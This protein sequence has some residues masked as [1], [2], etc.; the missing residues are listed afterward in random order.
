MEQQVGYIYVLTNKAMP[1]LLKIGYTQRTIQERVRE[2]SS[3]TGVPHDFEVAYSIETLSPEYKESIIHQHLSEY[4]VSKKGKEF[5]KISL[6]DAKHIIERVAKPLQP[7][8]VPEPPELTE[9][10]KEL[11]KAM[12]QELLKKKYE[13]RKKNIVKWW[14]KNLEKNLETEMGVQSEW[15]KKGFLKRLITKKPKPNLDIVEEYHVAIERLRQFKKAYTFSVF[16]KE[17]QG[18]QGIDQVIGSYR[19]EML[20]S[21]LGLRIK[22]DEVSWRKGD[23]D[24]PDDLVKSFVLGLEES[25]QALGKIFTLEPT[26]SFSFRFPESSYQYGHGKPKGGDSL[27]QDWDRCSSESDYFLRSMWGLEFFEDVHSLKNQPE[28]LYSDTEYKKRWQEKW[29]KNWWKKVD[30]NGYSSSNPFRTHSTP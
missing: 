18:I 20:E 10:E 7:P 24:Y 30:P 12:V 8:K 5:F 19:S 27:F 28:Y 16:L 26:A 21:Y 2:L 25:L 6:E 14:L 29:L 13:N 15:S 17:H 3:A 1:G 4:R 11:R 23:S 9:K 22:G